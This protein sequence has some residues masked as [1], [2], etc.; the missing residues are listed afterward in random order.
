MAR[1]RREPEQ[2]G[3]QRA[4]TASDRRIFI[5]HSATLRVGMVIFVY[6][7]HANNIPTG[8]PLSMG[9]TMVPLRC[10]GHAAN[11]SYIHLQYT[12]FFTHSPSLCHC[13]GA[14]HR[15]WALTRFTVNIANNFAPA[16]GKNPRAT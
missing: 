9:I 3:E 7:Q 5:G 2:V 8:A 16:A 1:G 15:G 14:H 11:W 12:I 10:T 6:T 13:G 4:L